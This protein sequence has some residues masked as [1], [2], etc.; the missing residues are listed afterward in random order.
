MAAAAVAAAAAAGP[1]AACAEVD[2]E[3]AA[4]AEAEAEVEAVVE[5]VAEVEAEAEAEVEAEAEAEADAVAEAG[6]DVEACNWAAGA[7]ADVEVAA[8]GVVDSPDRRGHRHQSRC[9]RSSRED[10]ADQV[11]VML[12][13]ARLVLTPPAV[14]FVGWRGGVGGKSAGVV[15]D[16]VVVPLPHGC[17][18]L[19]GERLGAF[20]SRPVR[21]L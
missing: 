20:V 12:M 6:V 16:R 3:A 1:A 15:I 13:L 5:A 11:L 10:P 9:L 4:A 14:V 21:D 7:V 17:C 2:L 18:S 8:A 19:W